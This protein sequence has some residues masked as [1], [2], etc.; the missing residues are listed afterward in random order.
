M[1]FEHRVAVHE[2]IELLRTEREC[3]DHLSRQVVLLAVGHRAALE[4]L[5]DAVADHLGMDAQI[6][7]V[8]QLH[9][10]GVGNGAIADL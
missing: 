7:L 1:H 9:D 5:Q 2:T 4:Q 8:A 3:G 6:V 10:H